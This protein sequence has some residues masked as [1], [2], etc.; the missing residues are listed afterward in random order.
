MSPT[1]YRVLLSGTAGMT[2]SSH[3]QAVKAFRQGLESALGGGPAQVVVA[4]ASY[5]QAVAPYGGEP[6]PLEASRDAQDAVERWNG[7]LAT[8]KEA[9]FLGWVRIPPMASFQVKAAL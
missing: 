8:A 3:D 5:L 4:H 7:A 9:A 6:L 1:M 2:E